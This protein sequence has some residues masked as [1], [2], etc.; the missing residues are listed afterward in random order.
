MDGREKPVAAGDLKRHWS[1]WTSLVELFARRRR[2][3][4][5]VAEAD[6]DGLYKQLL[7]SCSDEA[8]RADLPKRALYSYLAELVR[9]WVTPRTLEQADKEI[10]FDLWSKCE[11]AS[12][13]LGQRH[14]KLTRW[15]RTMLF[16]SVTI[17]LFVLI[18]MLIYQEWPQIGQWLSP[19]SRPLVSS[20]RHSTATERVFA[21]FV[22]LAVLGAYF[23]YRSPR[24]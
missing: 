21:L 16:W 20:I 22:G 7:N 15:L 5:R 14:R 8:E 23:L 19:W 13:A 10:L 4:F 18:G 6:Y 3:R 9:P 12:L 2:G 1:E 17:L 11:N 24:T